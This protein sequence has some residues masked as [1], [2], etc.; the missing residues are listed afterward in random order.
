MKSYKYSD[1]LCTDDVIVSND[2]IASNEKH[3]VFALPRT[4]LRGDEGIWTFDNDVSGNG[5]KV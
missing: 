2:V 5:Y 1:Y 4:H 3:P